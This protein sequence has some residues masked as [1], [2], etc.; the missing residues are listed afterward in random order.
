MWDIGPKNKIYEI[1][2]CAILALN[3]DRLL[4]IGPS[5][6]PVIITHNELLFGLF[7]VLIWKG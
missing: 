3:N 2:G 6:H 1:L 5:F 7:V 4:D